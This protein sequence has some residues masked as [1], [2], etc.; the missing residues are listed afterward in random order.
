MMKCRRCGHQ[1]QEGEVANLVRSEGSVTRNRI[2]DDIISAIIVCDECLR[3]KELGY[4]DVEP[5]YRPRE[6]PVVR[7]PKLTGGQAKFLALVA[8]KCVFRIPNRIMKRDL[9]TGKTSAANDM[10][11][12]LLKLKAFVWEVVPV[13]Q[14]VPGGVN[15][16]ARITEAGKEMLSEARA[17]AE[18]VAV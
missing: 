13:E 4:M 9:Y 3:G 12:D 15:A 18:Q 11:Y 16:W 1:L 2:V 8:E 7:T 5:L 14:R 17:A 10:G 6:H